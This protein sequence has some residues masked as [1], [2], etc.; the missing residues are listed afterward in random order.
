MS[1]D[2]I[3]ER[4]KVISN[5]TDGSVDRVFVKDKNSIR[6][7]MKSKDEFIFTYIS[8]DKWRLET[9]NAFLYGVGK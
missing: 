1:H 2:Y 3:Y 7:R 4:F 5:F 9:L 6:V 8:P